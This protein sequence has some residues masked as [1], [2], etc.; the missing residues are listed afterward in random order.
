MRNLEIFFF[1]QIKKKKEF[2]FRG[3]KRAQQLKLFWECIN[4]YGR[5]TQRITQE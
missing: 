5:S 3:E 1:F 2:K 4:N